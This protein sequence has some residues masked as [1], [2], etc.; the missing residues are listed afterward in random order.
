MGLGSFFK[1]LFGKASA[2]VDA[3]ADKA[4]DLA[5]DAIEKAKEQLEL[6][7]PVKDYYIDLGDNKTK[8]EDISSVEKSIE[9]YF[10]LKKS[11][12]LSR[13]LYQ[14]LSPLTIYLENQGVFS[15]IGF[16]FLKNL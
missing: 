9:P 2:S 16:V 12:L 13:I 3:I 5:G 11:K 6:L 8:I 10:N 1:G 15:D 7:K 4:E 14:Y